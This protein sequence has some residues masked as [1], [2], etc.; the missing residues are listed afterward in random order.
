ME[1]KYNLSMELT[2]NEIAK[3]IRNQLRSY[4]CETIVNTCLDTLASFRGKGVEELKSAPWLTLLIV[5]L[6]LEDRQ[7]PLQGSISCS[8]E[9]V[10]SIRQTLWNFN[11]M[12]HANDRSAVE[13]CMRAMGHQQMLFQSPITWSFLRWPVLISELP[14]THKMQT[15]FRGALGMPP[16]HF[17]AMCWAIYAVVLQHSNRISPRYFDGL[18]PILGMSIEAFIQRFSRT[19]PDLREE[20]RR[21][22]EVRET[23]V[24]PTSEVLEFPWLSR[25]P[26]LRLSSGELVVWH[27]QVLAR[28][29]EQAAHTALSMFGEAYTQ[30]FSKVYENYVRSLISEC[31]LPSIAEDA[32]KERYG[33][34]APSVESVIICP[35]ANVFVEAKMSL[36]PDT[37]VSSDSGQLVFNKLRRVREGIVQGWKL[38]DLVANDQE[39]WIDVESKRNFQIIV[40][41]RQLNVCNGDHL[42]RLFGDEVFNNICPGSGFGQPTAQQLALLPPGN[43][44]ILSIE[45]FEHLVGCIRKGEVDLG[46]LMSLAS[47]EQGNPSSSSFH[48]D[49]ILGRHTKKWTLPLV[50]ER[51]IERVRNSIKQLSR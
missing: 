28:G 11:W 37:V 23:K 24:R 50:Q 35:N 38:V 5:K 42:E 21:E 43:I 25:F 29:L 4:S 20:A 15:Q 26:M 36:F 7:V 1:L 51:A 8:N 12:A 31:A 41:S 39:H 47:E 33:D 30:S 27:D 10:H 45:E 6:A 13:L 49:Q 44:F 14:A 3:R 40:T 18:R 32:I 9:V 2:Y 16:D 17:V 48:F 46:T 34:N 22:A 19:L